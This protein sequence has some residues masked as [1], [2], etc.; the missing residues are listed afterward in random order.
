MRGQCLTDQELKKI[1]TKFEENAHHL[2]EERK[3]R[4][5]AASS[6]P[7]KTS[8]RPSSGKLRKPGAEAKA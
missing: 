2:H 6:K 7:R 8:P 1:L 4:S 3:R 5:G